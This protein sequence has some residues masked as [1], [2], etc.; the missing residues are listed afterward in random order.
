MTTDEAEV[1]ATDLLYSTRQVSPPTDL[2][3]VTG[4]LRGVRVSVEDLDNE[5]YLVDVPGGA[6]ILVNARSSHG[7]QRFTLAHELGHYVLRIGLGRPDG[8]SGHSEIERWCDRFAVG[9]LMPARWVREFINVAPVERRAARIAGAP[10]A[11]QVSRRAFWLRVPEV[12]DAWVFELI[13]VGGA[14]CLASA[15]TPAPP[16]EIV[17]A[18]AAC[19]SGLGRQAS[20]SIAT[21]SLQVS[22]ARISSDSGDQRSLAVVTSR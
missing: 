6:E 4:M 5:G 13:L 10:R 20:A 7:R 11:F 21:G 8:L 14:A 17:S 9:L 3:R 16:A 19:A 18:A 2:Y 15:I 1:V 12:M 22:C